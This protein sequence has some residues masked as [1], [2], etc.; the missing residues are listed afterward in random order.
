[1]VTGI[2]ELGTTLAVMGILILRSLLRLLVTAK[3]FLSSLILLM[4]MTKAMHSSETSFLTRATQRKDSEDCISP[5]GNF[6]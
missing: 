2:G 1:M 5:V 3:V 6:F 4:L